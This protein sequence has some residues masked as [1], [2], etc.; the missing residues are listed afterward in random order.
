VETQLLLAK[1]L[2]YVDAIEDTINDIE[3]LT[4]LI[5]GLIRYLKTK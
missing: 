1:R 5:Y 3:R 2:Q 4:K